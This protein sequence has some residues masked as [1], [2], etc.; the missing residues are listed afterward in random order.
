[1]GALALVLGSLVLVAVIIRLTVWA[2]KELYNLAPLI[3]ILTIVV[4]LSYSLG[5]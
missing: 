4:F 2:T 5:G 3:L 1:M